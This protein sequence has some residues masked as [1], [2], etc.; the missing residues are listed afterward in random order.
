MASITYTATREIASGHA[1]NSLYAFDIGL[2]TQ[3]RS[4]KHTRTRHKSIG[5]Q[6]ETWLQ[7]IDTFF[8]VKVEPVEI[9]DARLGYMREFLASVADGSQFLIDFDGTVA[10]AVNPQSFELESDNYKE[11]R[12][13]PR[14][15]QMAFKVRKI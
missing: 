2:E 9:S 4:S 6:T 5:G 3:D 1:A 15:I 7:S 10:A 11:S 12:L 13:G 8:D 14:Y